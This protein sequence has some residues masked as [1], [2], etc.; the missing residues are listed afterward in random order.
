MGKRQSGGWS[1][2][3]D[4]R[5]VYWLCEMRYSSSQTAYELNKEFPNRANGAKPFTR[6]SV[7]WRVDRMHLNKSAGFIQKEQTRRAPRPARLM[8]PR[9]PRLAGPRVKRDKESNSTGLVVYTDAVYVEREKF[10]PLSTC[11]WIFDTKPMTMCGAECRGSYCTKHA[12]DVYRTVAQA[13]K[14]LEYSRANQYKYKR[15]NSW[16]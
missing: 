11:Q 16:F 15:I 4:K 13:R 10:K 1:E 3:E 14:D 8:Q 12:A 6:N 2:E 7:I 5:L 9:A